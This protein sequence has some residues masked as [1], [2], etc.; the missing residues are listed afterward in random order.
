MI[1]D[2]ATVNLDHKNATV[3]RPIIAIQYHLYHG[4]PPSNKEQL[5]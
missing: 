3:L 5:F 2:E 1:L 4:Y